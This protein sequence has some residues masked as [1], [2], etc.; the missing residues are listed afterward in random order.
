MPYTIPN[1]GPVGALLEMMG[2]HTWRP[3]HVHYKLRHDG[4]QELI[5]QAYFEGGDYVDDDCCEG[6]VPPEFVKPHVKE[7]GK[8][9]FDVDFTIQRVAA[10]VAA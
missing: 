7:N 3:A 10:P 9:I 5:T 1:T 8:V 4:F 2:R 6:I